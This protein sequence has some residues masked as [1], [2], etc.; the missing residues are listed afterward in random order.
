MSCKLFIRSAATLAAAAFL[1]V[2][3]AASWA[4]GGCGCEAPS[5]TVYHV[6]QRCHHCRHCP[7][8]GMVV[9]SMA[10]M[11]AQMMAA[12]MMAAPIA[13][14]QPVAVAAAPAQT[15]T[16]TAQTAPQL[17]FSSQASC[18][19]AGLTQEQ[20]TRAVAQAMANAQSANGS[21]GAAAGSQ[22]DKIQKLQDKLDKLET[23]TL[24]LIQ[25]IR[26]KQQ[27]GN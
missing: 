24:T 14:A 20:I 3:P 10:V 2:S 27:E 5:S 23:Q 17:T 6:H 15:F 21:F 12:P 26:A 1:F 19:G 7:P 18:A 22:D 11:P 4:G 9:P 25:L 13:F 8:V 16:L